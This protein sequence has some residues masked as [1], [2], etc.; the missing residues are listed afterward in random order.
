MVVVLVLIATMAVSAQS[1]SAAHP[2]DP[3]AITIDGF[4]RDPVTG[5]VEAAYVVQGITYTQDQTAGFFAGLLYTA[6]HDDTL[7]FAFDQ[8]VFINDNTYGTAAIG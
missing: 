3:G 6:E 8:S 1:V 7:Y 2:P 5:V 4:V